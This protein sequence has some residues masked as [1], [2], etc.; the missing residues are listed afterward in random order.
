MRTTPR[1]GRPRSLGSLL[2]TSLRGS[3]CQLMTP[4]YVPSSPRTNLIRPGGRF[5]SLWVHHSPTIASEG[6]LVED[7]MDSSVFDIWAD[8]VAGAPRAPA[9]RTP[10]IR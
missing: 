3:D 6:N 1:R 10:A 5:S 4:M 7:R 2:W 9:A 8:E